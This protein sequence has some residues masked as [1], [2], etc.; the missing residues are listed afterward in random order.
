MQR[1]LFAVFREKQ[2]QQRLA[3]EHACEGLMP[4]QVKRDL[5]DYD[6]QRKHYDSFVGAGYVALQFVTMHMMVEA[7][8]GGALSH[9]RF[10][11]EYANWRVR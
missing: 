6:E 1:K 4:R 5:K 2:V 10:T 3:R 9:E 7:K 8:A 11:E